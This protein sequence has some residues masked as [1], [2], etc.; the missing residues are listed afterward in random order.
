MSE[1]KFSVETL[2]QKMPKGRFHKK[3]YHETPED[4]EKE[5]KA[6]R[7]NPEGWREQE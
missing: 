3:G 2:D 6:L 1:K 7:A 5:K 4:I